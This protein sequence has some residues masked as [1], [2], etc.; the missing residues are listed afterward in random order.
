M[1]WKTKHPNEMNGASQ[2]RKGR[3]HWSF[4]VWLMDFT[5]RFPVLP[6]FQQTLWF[7][8]SFIFLTFIYSVCVSVHVYSPTNMQH[9]TYVKVSEDSSLFSHCRDPGDQIQIL[10]LVAITLAHRAIW[11]APLLFSFTAK[12]YFTMCIHH[13]FHAFVWPCNLAIVEIS[14]IN[15]VDISLLCLTLDSFGSTLSSER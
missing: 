8:S 4:S 10:T 5:Q 1:K 9:S 3:G 15:T 11:P 13:I 2:V 7:C 6:V 14:T 12:Q